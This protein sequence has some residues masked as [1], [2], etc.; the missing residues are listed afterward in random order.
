MATYG[1]IGSP[2]IRSPLIHPRARR[3]RPTTGGNA[4]PSCYRGLVRDRQRESPYERI[5]QQRQV[6]YHD[7]EEFDRIAFAVRALRKLRPRRLKVAVYEAS[8]ALHV[9][10][11]RD[12]GGDARW[13]MVGIPKHASREHIAYALAELAGVESVPYAVQMLLTEGR[14]AS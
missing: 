2:G 8:A 3:R 6:E 5:D 1:G 14:K 7:H 10:S 9:S 12:H 4:A 11:G 13:A